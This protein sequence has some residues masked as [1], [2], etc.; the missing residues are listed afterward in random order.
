LKALHFMDFEP[1]FPS[2]I[3]KMDWKLGTKDFSQ[4]WLW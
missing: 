3:M 1:Y 4:Q 2:G